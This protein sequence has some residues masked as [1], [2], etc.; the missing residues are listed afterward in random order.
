MLVVGVRQDLW[1]GL[2]LWLCLELAFTIIVMVRVKRYVFFKA[3][4]ICYC[5]ELDALDLRLEI[6]ITG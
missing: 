1:F 6:S 5:L 2:D 4:V 3:V